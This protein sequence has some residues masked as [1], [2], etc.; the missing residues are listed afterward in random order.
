MN[1]ESRNGHIKLIFKFF[2]D[3]ILMAHLIH[4]GDFYCIAGA[5]I[6]RYY[7]PIY[8][9]YRR[10]GLE[11]NYSKNQCIHYAIIARSK[12]NILSTA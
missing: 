3:T 5:I 10:N 6:N 12:N 8:R 1:V 9:G 7:N 11:T 4:L 2:Q